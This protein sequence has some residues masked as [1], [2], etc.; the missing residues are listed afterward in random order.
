MGLLE[1]LEQLAHEFLLQ[2]LRFLQ[3]LQVV[4]VNYYSWNLQVLQVE[5]LVVL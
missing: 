1:F 5:V 2:W 4:D 3:L